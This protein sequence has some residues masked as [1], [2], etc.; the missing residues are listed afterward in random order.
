MKKLP[1]PYTNGKIKWSYCRMI[2]QYGFMRRMSHSTVSV[3]RFTSLPGLHYHRSEVHNHILS[4][5]SCNS[6]SGIRLLYGSKSS[7]H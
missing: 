1:T 4:A 2:Q 6:S 7:Q 5:S 3:L